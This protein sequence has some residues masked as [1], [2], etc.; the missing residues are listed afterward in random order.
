M[1]AA[2]PRWAA[3]GFA[4]GLIKVRKTSAWGSAHVELVQRKLSAVC[5]TESGVGR[6]FVRAK[7]FF[8]FFGATLFD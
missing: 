6:G 7:N 3:W 1:D 2:G 8:L 4:R 5:R